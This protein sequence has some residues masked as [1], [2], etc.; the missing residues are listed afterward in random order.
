M[1]F[2]RVQVSENLIR[3]VILSCALIGAG[4]GVGYKIERLED[5][6]DNLAFDICRTIPQNEW[7]QY[8]TCSSLPD[9]GFELTSG[10]IP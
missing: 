9:G 5:K 6:I 3:T 4:F 8:R 7:F 1:T 2:G 10:V